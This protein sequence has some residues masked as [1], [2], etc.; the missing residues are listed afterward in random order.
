[1]VY[2]HYAPGTPRF[3]PFNAADQLDGVLA[4]PTKTAPPPALGGAFLSAVPDALSSSIKGTGEVH[5]RSLYLLSALLS[6]GALP[7]Y[8]TNHGSVRH[9]KFEFTAFAPRPH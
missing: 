1:M 9:R 5:L 7:Q 4:T 3:T 6:S 8:N 2:C